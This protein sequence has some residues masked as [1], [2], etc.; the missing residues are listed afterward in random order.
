M[1]SNTEHLLFSANLI[2]LLFALRKPIGFAALM[3]Q[4]RLVM[5]ASYL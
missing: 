5:F 4:L 1:V 3:E 2:I